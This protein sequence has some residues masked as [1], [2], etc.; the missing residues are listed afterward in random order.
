[1]TWL[2]KTANLRTM[3]NWSPPK[4][5][6]R[7]LASWVAFWIS[8]TVKLA[9]APL[10]VLEGGLGWPVGSIPTC[11]PGNW[12]DSSDIM[13][14]PEGDGG[15]WYKRRSRS[16]MGVFCITIHACTSG[17]A[18]KRSDS[19]TWCRLQ[20]VSLMIGTPINLVR[21]QIRLHLTVYKAIP[22]QLWYKHLKAHPHYTDSG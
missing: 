7:P 14:G 6:W 9:W 4:E 10:A 3:C 15:M 22:R 2:L 12:A 18:T 19:W 11:W 20:A 8:S 21:G 16:H 1:M 5:I 13:W 17:S